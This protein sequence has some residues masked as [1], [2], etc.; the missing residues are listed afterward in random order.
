[1]KVDYLSN[2]GCLCYE[3]NAC[4]ADTRDNTCN[5]DNVIIP[6]VSVG[7]MM[8]IVAAR[9]TNSSVTYDDGG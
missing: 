6:G 5:N 3:T 4:V 1:M 2:E 7:M 8:M 9:S